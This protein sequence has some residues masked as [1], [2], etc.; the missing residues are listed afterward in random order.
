M[1]PEPMVLELPRDPTAPGKARAFVSRFAQRIPR[2]QAGDLRLLTSELVTNAVKYGGT[3][4][5]Q[6][7]LEEIEDRRLRVEIVDNGEGFAAQEVAD[8]RDREDLDKVGGW[9]LPIVEALAVDW[10]SFEGS[11]HVWFE[12]ELR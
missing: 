1:V 6:L 11:T 8:A 7:R 2:D 12:F 5:L 3:G 9:G 4:N 10:G